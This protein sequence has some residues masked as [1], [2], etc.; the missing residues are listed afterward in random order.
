MCE[1]SACDIRVILNIISTYQRRAVNVNSTSFPIFK[2]H[3]ELI[4][5]DMECSASLHRNKY[6]FRDH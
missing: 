5:A 4:K 6:V 1:T 3:I 2:I